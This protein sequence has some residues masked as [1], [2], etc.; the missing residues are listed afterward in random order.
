MSAPKQFSITA[1][2]VATE[3]PAKRESAARVERGPNLFLAP[4]PESGF[5]EGYLFKSY[6]D[7]VWYDLPVEGGWV[8]D[9]IAKGPNK[10]QET[11]RL[12]GDAAEAVRQLREAATTLGIGVAI[13]FFPVYFKGGAKKG[14]EDPSK[15]LIKYLG[16][17]RK[18]ARKPKP[19][20]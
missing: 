11:E 9:T 18:A 17:K 12:D 4:H 7:G 5:P 10:G 8:V 1:P 19:V 20:A 15:V 3:I 2:V 13:K 16:Q 14:Q 6:T